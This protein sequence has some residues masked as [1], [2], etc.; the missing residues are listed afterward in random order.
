M[1]MPWGTITVDYV[2]CPKCRR[3]WKCVGVYS[4][5]IKECKD[6]VNATIVGGCTDTFNTPDRLEMCPDCR[7]D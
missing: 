1:T 6:C 4:D 5:Y 2:Y 7:R 3:R